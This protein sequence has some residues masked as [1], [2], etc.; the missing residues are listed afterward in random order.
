[1]LAACKH[2]HGRHGDQRAYTRHV[3]APVILV[4]VGRL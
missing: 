2:G 4:P 1:V 3:D